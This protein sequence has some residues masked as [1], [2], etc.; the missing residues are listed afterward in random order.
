MFSNS[1]VK[2][3]IVAIFYNCRVAVEKALDGAKDKSPPSNV[4]FDDSGNFI[5]YP[6]MAGIKVVNIVTNQL[7]KLIGKVS[8][9]ISLC[10]RDSAVNIF[11]SGRSYGAL[12]GN[13]SL[14][15][16][17]TRICRNR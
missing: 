12:S 9:F 16:A 11:S 6:T 1:E 3:Y 15:R 8:L 13:S 10:F 14:P 2:T 17:H 7:V 5:F 4:I